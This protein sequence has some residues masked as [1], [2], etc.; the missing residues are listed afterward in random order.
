MTDA[1][2]DIAANTDLAATGVTDAM[3]GDDEV[4]VWRSTRGA[5]C[6]H[7]RRCPH[8]DHDLVEATVHGEELVCPAHGWSITTTGEV[9]KRNEAGR[10]DPKGRVRTWQ[11]Q[12]HDGMI[13]VKP[14]E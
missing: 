11:A 9:L 4:V 1:W 10:A 3:I 13:A 6:V 8:L 14:D 5:L 2:T 12:E 7:Q